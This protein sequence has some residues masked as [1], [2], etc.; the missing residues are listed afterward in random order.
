MD[1]SQV[2]GTF[3]R[4]L[5]LE[6]HA[7]LKGKAQAELNQPRIVHLRADYTKLCCSKRGSWR[8]ELH[9]VKKIEELG[10]EGETI[11]FAYQE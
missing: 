7:T 10:A 1:W 6:I 3:A 11:L 4:A 2:Q 9:P 8:P 5:Y